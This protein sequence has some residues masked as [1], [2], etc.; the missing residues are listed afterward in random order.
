MKILYF[1]QHFSTPQG[2]AG[3]RSYEM[4]RRA[5]A[6]GH[7]VTMVC[8]TYGQGKTG[9]EGRFVKRSRR[10]NVD[11]INVI[12]FDLSYSNSDGFLKRSSTFLRYALGAIRLALRDRYDV[13]FATTTPLTAALPGIAAR[14]LRSKPFVFEVR[15]L[16]PELP[17]AMGVITNPLVLGAMG[18]LEFVAYR[19]ANRLVALSPGIAKGIE[20]RGVRPEKI[21][22]IPN[23]CDFELFGPHIE[24]ERPPGPGSDD[25]LAVFTGTHGPA[26]GLS[27]LLEAARV[28]K[29]RGRE[30]IAIVLIGSGKEKDAL[31]ER[32]SS[33]GLDNVYFHDPV[34]KARLSRVIASADIGI[35]CLANV[36]AFYFGTSPN[37]FFD[38]IAAGR[39]VLNNY[40]GW[41]A[42]MIKQE[43]C[44]YA[45]APEDPFAMAD[46][47]EHAAENREDLKAMGTRSR[48][49]AAREFD[50]ANLSKRWIDWVVEGVER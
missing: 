39:P 10:G 41:L 31:L 22:L 8:G 21:A 38:Y 32:A 35:Q 47:L 2:A 50:R 33:E 34:P 3:T 17:K 18:V 43:E 7:E 27:A 5:V 24:P 14:W 13:C 36:K 30:D 12:E 20:R 11:G 46:A 16:W 6:E 28:L 42:G 4:A 49:L 45:V 48:A 26:N 9:L 25:L 15:D 44:G 1:H 19:S 23:G 29:S 40:P 37:K